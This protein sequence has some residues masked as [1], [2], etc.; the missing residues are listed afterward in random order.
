MLANSQATDAQ[1]IAALRSQAQATAKQEALAVQMAETKGLLAR[2]SS[3]LE[4]DALSERT[5]RGQEASE[6]LDIKRHEDSI[7]MWLRN[8]QDALKFEERQK[9]SYPAG[10]V[11]VTSAVHVR[12]L[13]EQSLQSTRQHLANR[14]I[15]I[16]HDREERRKAIEARAKARADYEAEYQRGVQARA[17]EAQKLARQHEEQLVN[18][19]ITLQREQ[20]RIAKEQ[21]EQAVREKEAEQLRIQQQATE[22]ARKE[23]ARRAAEV[24]KAARLQAAQQE[25]ERTRVQVH[26][27]LK[28]RLV[29]ASRVMHQTPEALRSLA[30]SVRKQL[31]EDDVTGASGDDE[32]TL[33]QLLIELEKCN[34][35]NPHILSAIQ[36]GEFKNKIKAITEAHE[37][38]I[39]TWTA[40][41][42]L[43]WSQSMK[44]SRAQAASLSEIIA[45]LCRAMALATQHE[46]RT[47]Q[48]LS[49][50][51]LLD[52]N[53]HGRLAQI[54][55][56]EGKSMIVAMLAAINVLQ[57]KKPDIVTSSSV[58]AKREAEHQKAFFSV[59]DITVSHNGHDTEDVDRHM[60]YKADV[61]YGDAPHFQGDVLRQDYRQEKTRGDRPFDLI[62]ADEVDSMLVDKG[63]QYV[64]LGSPKPLMEE[65]TPLFIS[66]WVV[67]QH[68]KKQERPYTNEALVSVLTDYIHELLEKSNPVIHVPQHLK[69]FARSQAPHWAKS[70]VTA[71]EV[72]HRDKDYVIAIDEHQQSIIAPV[73][74]IHT[75]VIYSGPQN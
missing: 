51:V 1:R 67:L 17:I 16:Q 42:I 7:A 53:Q 32:K 69:S 2:K 57:G 35:N 31:T 60:C 20:L 30:L 61:V 52:A 6:Q 59:L 50:L 55:T 40:E 73:D 4:Q 22:A 12:Q 63:S 68:I 28:Q 43:A 64:M 54:A 10:H 36:H 5:N 34:Q 66:I 8:I 45:V 3:Y 44:A 15:R 14:Q 18:E 71:S 41:A 26:S 74:Y 23:E 38:G 70:A 25:D 29:L 72:F 46:P 56:G 39:N 11:Q 21:R 33:A 9:A 37:G 65:L 27:G 75:G 24:E 13:H 62:I 49:L 47:A 48:L 58:L 19:E